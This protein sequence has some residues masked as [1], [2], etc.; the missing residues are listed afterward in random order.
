MNDHRYHY[1]FTTFVSIIFTS[2]IFLVLWLMVVQILK[3][4]RCLVKLITVLIL[5]INHTSSRSEKRHFTKKVKSEV[6]KSCKNERNLTL[7]GVYVL[8]VLPYTLQGFESIYKREIPTSAK[9]MCPA[10]I[11]RTSNATPRRACCISLLS[12]A[13]GIGSSSRALERSD[14]F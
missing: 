7:F 4:V 3:L 12:K 10:F 5:Y 13:S 11:S 9:W 2:F 6:M 1:M 8:K 14:Y